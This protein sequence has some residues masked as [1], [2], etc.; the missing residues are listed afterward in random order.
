MDST[1]LQKITNDQTITNDWHIGPGDICQLKEL[2]EEILKF[3]PIGIQV[4]DSNFC[5]RLWN[6]AM[7]RVTHV[8]ASRVVGRNAF[9]IFPNNTATV[10]L[11][12][13]CK[14]VLKEGRPFFKKSNPRFMVNGSPV[15][16]K[17]S[18]FPL[19][20]LHSH[21]DQQEDAQADN[22]SQAGFILI[23][24]EDITEHKSIENELEEEARKQAKG[25]EEWEKNFY[26]LVEGSLEGV[27]IS[28]GETI[29]Y[30]NPSL[31][32]ILGYKDPRELIGQ[33]LLITHPSEAWDIL[34]ER[35]ER[36]RQGKSN[37]PR[38][39]IKGKKKD[40]TVI[41]LDVSTS[42]VCANGEWVTLTT[43]RDI[44]EKK[45]IEEQERKIHEHILHSD[46][47]AAMGRLSAGIAHEINN[48]L[49][50][51]SGRIQ[52]L[53]TTYEDNKELRHNFASMKR[54]CDRIG[55]IVDNL[56][57][58]SKQKDEPRYLYDIN[59]VIEDAISMFATQTVAKGVRVVKQYAHDLPPVIMIASQIQ[60]VCVNLFINAIDATKLGDEI[61]ISTKLDKAKKCAMIIFKDTGVG[62]PKDIQD[63]IFE[64]FFT[65]KEM[66]RGSG[67]GLSISSGIIKAHKG[68]IRV[69]SKEGLGTIFTVKLPLPAPEDLQLYGMNRA[70]YLKSPL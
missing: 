58:F 29:I 6:P 56:L 46:R 41:E 65:T 7:E 15:Y 35:V 63:K 40:G 25:M 17:L 3:V 16:Y 69:R 19:H 26:D 10:E 9:E 32:R 60:Q 70:R 12:E 45:K 53:L 24:L 50:V 31:A 52:E 48:P 28:R 66:G 27:G 2:S 1:D 59:E 67:L 5:I 43:V 22:H 14:R 44:T 68:S 42:N 62:I 51:L 36:R 13:I 61:T 54:V 11:E 37:A 57:F 21:Q 8:P 47:L 34:R 18:V 23:C 33:N 49:A 20:S 64:P 30:V 55:K 39:E 38:F 4:L